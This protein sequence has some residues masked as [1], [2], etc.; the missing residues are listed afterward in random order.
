[1]FNFKKDTDTGRSA[2][3]KSSRSSSDIAK[4]ASV[5]IGGK[6][7]IG[8]TVVIDGNITSAEDL[9][10]EGK[11][12]GTITATGHEVTVGQ[13]G[14]LNANISAKTVRIEGRV[15]GDISGGEKVIIS[16]TGNVLGNID[17]PRVTLEDGAKFKG[18]IEMDPDEQP[19]IKAVPNS[20]SD[21]FP[22]AA[23]A[24]KS[25]AS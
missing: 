19:A 1:M 12:S 13:A 15:E 25:N 21:L 2:L 8:S 6:T 11:V 18:S 22:G 16:K 23:S 24:E 14:Q 10:I 7:M 17:A 9:I 4:R 20:K 5:S 3:N